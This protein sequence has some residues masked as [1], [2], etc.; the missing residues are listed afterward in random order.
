MRLSHREHGQAR[1][2][3]CRQGLVD[4]LGKSSDRHA[5]SV[6]LFFGGLEK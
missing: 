3:T 4:S 6:L 5:V 2:G 1:L